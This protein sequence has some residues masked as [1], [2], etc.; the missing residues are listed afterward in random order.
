MMSL[1]LATSSDGVTWQRSSQTPIYN[2]GWVEDIMVVK[3][4]GTY[5]MFAEGAAAPAKLPTESAGCQ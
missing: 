2:D 4:D 3:Q 5:Y 1:G